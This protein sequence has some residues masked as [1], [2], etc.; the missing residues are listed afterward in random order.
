MKLLQLLSVFDISVDFIYIFLIVCVFRLL[1]F[2]K[3]F[4]KV[5]KKWDAV[6]CSIYFL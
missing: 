2:N 4:E 3:F 1:A 5:R 6:S